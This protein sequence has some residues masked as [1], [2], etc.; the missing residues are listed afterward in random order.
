MTQS[1]ALDILKLGENIFLTG[2]PGAGKTY[3]L[4]EYIRFLQSRDVDAAITAYTGI[5]ASHLSGR[6]LH[7][8]AGLSF[9]P[10]TPEQERERIHASKF[11]RTRIQAAKVLIIDEISML[12]PA[13]F[14]RVD[15][16][17]KTARG[18]LEPF[19]GLQL[20]CC[21][22]FFQIP[23]VQSG[24]EQLIA[25]AAN[26]GV[27]GGASADTEAGKF[28][29]DSTAWKTAGMR[30]CYLHEQHR[31]GDTKLLGILDDIRA[32]HIS[33]ESLALLR[34]RLKAPVAAPIGIA[35]L[36]THNENVDAING[37]ELQKLSGPQVVYEVTERGSAKFVEKLKKDHK[38]DRLVLRKGAR[39]MF[40]RNNRG[41]GYVNGTLGEVVDF[42]GG[43]SGAAAG[44]SGNDENSTGVSAGAGV[45][46][47][48]TTADSVEVSPVVLT[49]DRRRILV[50][51][52]SWDLEED[53][54]VRASVRQM[55]LK[56]AW[57]ITVHKSQ[58]MTLDAAEIDL[59]RAFDRGMGYVALSRVKQ[60]ENISLLGLNEL[61]LQVSPRIKALD[62]QF[63]EQ[64]A[65]TEAYLAEFA[66]AGSGGLARAQEE[67]LERAREDGGGSGGEKIIA[68]AD[69]IHY[70][71][72]EVPVVDFE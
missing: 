48:P 25:G 49:F 53:G 51:R 15:F 30:T 55:P 40:T 57:A 59:S 45:E 21:G 38:L 18:S 64:S 33:A 39:V 52:E 9:T 19:G 34:S 24:D 28:V 63:W 8:W 42:V 70:E 41:M 60:L 2:A 58:G 6:T 10:L 43:G 67:F 23:P 29:I 17:C 37:A 69:D 26:G 36:Y 46:G 50:T 44:A 47:A 31:Q 1:Q 72:D 14:D 4:N 35:R 56:L 65:E 32:G 12:H 5:A 27:G 71:L 66:V 13:E 11:L 62:A 54:K 7:S 22:D 20:I 16:I 61:A 68:L 3:L